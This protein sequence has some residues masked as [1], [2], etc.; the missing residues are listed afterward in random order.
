MSVCSA[1]V[2]AV[3]QEQDALGAGVLD[4]PVAEVDGG[5]GLAGAGGHLDQGAR[6]RFGERFFETADRL[7]LAVAHCRSSDE[8][9]AS[10]PAGA[11]RV[12]G[13]RATPQRL[14]AVEGEDLAR[15]RMRVALVAEEGLGAGA[16]R[17][18]SGAFPVSAEA[19]A[20]GC[21]VVARLLSDGGERGAFPLRL[22]DADRRAVHEEEVIAPAGNEGDF[23]QR[24]AA[25]GRKVEKDL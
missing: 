22:D 18:G 3:H 16:T 17:T 7:D 2:V 6:A 25:A 20:G 5:E 13:S 21:S 8:R 24:D 15:A 4:E 11:R 9:R 12:S 23:T 19:E 1:E 10:A 14:R